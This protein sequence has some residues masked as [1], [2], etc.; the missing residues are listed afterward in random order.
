M[1]GFTTF[2]MR[3]WL[4]M[5][6]RPTVMTTPFLRVTRAHPEGR[7]PLLFA[8]ELFELRGVLPYELTPQLITADS[9]LFLRAVRLLPPD[10][11]TA[12]ELNCGCPSPNSVGRDAGSGILRDPKAFATTIS[13]M[14][15][16]LGPQRLAVKMRLGFASAD[17]FATLLQSIATLP[18]A[19]LTVHGRTRA[20]GYR[21]K[22]R[23]DLIQQAAR[24]AMAPTWAS[25]DVCGIETAA[26]LQTAAPGVA[27]V[28]I[29]RGL[30]RNP[31]VFEELRCGTH[32]YITA[33]TL[34][35]ALLCF[36]LLHELTITAPAKLITKVGR[37]HFADLCGTSA[38][39]WE[40]VTAELTSM[41]GGYPFIL[42]TDQVSVREL[43]ALPLSPTAWARVRM[44]WAYLRS[45]LPEPFHAP[46]LMRARSASDFFS[47]FFAASASAMQT[48][49]AETFIL[50][51]QLALDDCYGGARGTS[52]P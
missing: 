18:L 3:L 4:N 52:N 41:V 42:G 45:S 33:A 40:R 30:L 6:A 15:A 29:G 38:Q 19:R 32:Q 9:Q 47:E 17:E 37:G 5:A 26:Q 13:G 1:E 22:A 16:S 35:N 24:V 43:A 36:G 25:G 31:W 39:A 44:L 28:V 49:G 48:L 14:V 50:R 8:P 34:A 10:V 21:G 27:G 51:H 23:W 2:P 11:S 46:R 20:D 7:L 12:V